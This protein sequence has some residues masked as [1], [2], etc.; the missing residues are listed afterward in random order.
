MEGASP[1]VFVIDISLDGEDGIELIDYL[2]SRS[3]KAKIFGLLRP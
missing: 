2:K 3:S 1:D